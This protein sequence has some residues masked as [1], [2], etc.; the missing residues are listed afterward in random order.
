[1]L[2]EALPGDFEKRPGRRRLAR[3]V[4]SGGV[5]VCRTRRRLP[6]LRTG[7]PFGRPG[8]ARYEL[9][10]LRRRRARVSV[11]D[12]PGRRRRGGPRRLETVEEVGRVR[13][14]V[15]SREAVAGLRRDLGLAPEGTCVSAALR[16]RRRA[17]G[18]HDGLVLVPGPAPARASAQGEGVEFL[19]RRLAP[20]APERAP[21]GPVRVRGRRSGLFQGFFRK[22]PKPL[23]TL[24][25][26]RRDSVRGRRG[27]ARLLGGGRARGPAAF[28]IRAADESDREPPGADRALLLGVREQVG[29][30]DAPEAFAPGLG[31]APPLRGRR[32]ARRRGPMRSRERRLARSR[33]VRTTTTTGRSTKRR[34]RASAT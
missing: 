14:T 3:P 28:T 2:E 6:E 25:A 12:V 26:G 33:R 32:A 5:L 19:G 34:T 1:V 15:G 27:V 24:D 23:R 9:P 4:P 29:R 20:R 18:R 13:R 30:R 11:G 16:H 22:V 17:E 21:H 31:K 7:A 10:P 8:E